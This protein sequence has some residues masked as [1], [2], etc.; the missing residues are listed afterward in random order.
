MILLCLWKNNIIGF[1]LKK[2]KKTSSLKLLHSF[3]HS[4][5]HL[6][7]DVARS[8]R[9]PHTCT[10][11]FTLFLSLSIYLFFS[12]YINSR[13][14]IQSLKKFRCAKYMSRSQASMEWRW[15][16]VC[17]VSF[18][19]YLLAYDRSMFTIS[20]VGVWPFSMCT[21]CR[22][23]WTKLL[24]REIKRENERGKKSESATTIFVVVMPQHAWQRKRKS[25]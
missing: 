13:R 11:S 22:L 16:C 1:E 17:D 6:E 18:F 9:K 24:N 14:S 7:F 12:L 19:C 3:I 25:K 20:L 5:S 8:K 4:F 15:S 21:Q 2:P 23:L 10:H